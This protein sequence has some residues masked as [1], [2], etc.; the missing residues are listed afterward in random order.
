MYDFGLLDPVWAGTKAAELTSD[1]AFAQAMLDVETAWCRAQI[2]SGTAPQAI[3]DAVDAAS[4]VADYNLAQ[5]AAKTPDGAN[6]LIP[7][8]SQ[9]RANV[10]AHDTAA[11]DYVHR[12]AT[13][14][15]IIDTAL[16]LLASRM[17]EHTVTKVK[18]AVGSLINLADEHAETVMIGR[19]LDQHAQPITFGFRVS[20]WIEALGSAGEHFEET[21]TNLPVQ[22][23]GAVGTST[24]WVDYFRTT[25]PETDP[26]QPVAAQRDVLAAELGLASASVWHANRV[27]ILE[28]GQTAFQITAAAGKLANDVLTAV[29][30]EHGELGEP[31]K[32]GRGGSSAMPHKQN[33]V[34]SI[35]LKNAAQAAAGY[36]NTLHTGVIANTA[37]RADGGWHTE[38]SALRALLRTTGAVAEIVAELAAGLRVYPAAMR[39]NLA[40]YGPYLF[41]SRLSQWLAPIVEA[42]GGADSGQGKQ[43]VESICTDA[44]ASGT[45]LAQALVSRLPDGIVKPEAIEHMLEPSGYTGG[46][47]AIVAA[48][49]SRYRKWS[50]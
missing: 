31:T 4:D 19:S 44:L 14:Q 43:L 21:I 38:W 32:A 47:A 39:D 24:W 37:E 34:L 29:Q 30:A 41:I 35:R 7:L 33:P 18:A 28:V 6:A 12:G 1:T 46:A 26:M 13:S 8:L 3:S 15:D 27:P 9:L 10:A 5:I 48:V 50:T 45:P 11:A 16:M 2:R 17:G 20:Q 23:G 40:I 22:W 25:Q 42:H 36:L 49:N